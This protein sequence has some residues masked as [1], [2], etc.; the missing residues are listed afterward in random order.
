MCSETVRV[1]L[2]ETST[3]VSVLL[4]GEEASGKTYSV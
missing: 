2:A 1:S 4:S 3:V